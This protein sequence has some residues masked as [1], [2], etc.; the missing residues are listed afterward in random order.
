M[1][2]TLFIR[3]L[4]MSFMFIAGLI[5]SNIALPERFGIIS[6]LILNASLLS[7]ITG[8]GTESIVLH[9]VARNKWKLLKTL[10]FVWY[11]IIVQIFLFLILEFL[12]L[13]FWNR[14]LLSN[15]NVSYLAI[16]VIYFMGL[17]LSEKYMILLYSFQRTLV[18]NIVMACVAMIYTIALILMYYIIKMEFLTAL[19][20]FA[21][22]S[23]I[24]GTALFIIFHFKNRIIDT[25]SLKRK[26]FFAAIGLSFIVMVTN[27]IQLAAYRLDF[28]I[29]KYFYS[30]YEVGLYAQANKFANLIWIIPNVLSQLLIT[31]FSSIEKCFVPKIFSTAFYLNL[32]GVLSTIICTNLFYYFYLEHEY[33]SGLPSFYMMLPGYFF[34]ALVIY[35]AAYFS[36]EGKFIYN[37]VGS[38]I[39]FFL[40]LISDFILI[41]GYGI[42]GAAWSN[43]ITYSIVFVVYLFFINKTFSVPW[44]EFFLLRKKDLLR[45][46]K[47][48]S[49]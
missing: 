47:F 49:R 1:L 43:T 11:G 31:K 29:L 46:A 20:C 8:L 44:N 39:C 12:S 13:H 34:W 15:E 7:I 30:N 3:M 5:L 22:Q 32:I 10:Q 27:I 28:W 41:P 36:W 23:L 16:D 18:A 26:E 42:Q 38:S 33:R 24:Q 40:I 25:E 2:R 45:I 21:L 6:L 35:I 37:L 4:Y 9:K 14:T 48:V 17:I 19:Y